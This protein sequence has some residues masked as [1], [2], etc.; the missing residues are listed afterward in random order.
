MHVFQRSM[1]ANNLA[2]I[3]AVFVLA[4]LGGSVITGLL[5]VSAFW[6]LVY[7]L[8]GRIRPKFSAGIAIFSIVLLAYVAVNIL[9]FIVNFGEVF[10]EPLVELR[11]IAPQ[12][13]FLAAIPIMWRLAISPGESLLPALWRGAAIGA[14]AVLPLALFQLYGLGDRAEGG[15]GN[16]IPFALTSALLSVTSLAG[17]LDDNRRFRILAGAGFVSGYICVF[18]A[19]TKGL[20]PVPLVCALVFA[21]VFFRQRIRIGQAVGL[22]VLLATLVI[23]GLYGSGSHKRFHDV[24]QRAMGDEHVE[25]DASY[26]VRWDIWVKAVSAIADAPL[27]GHG[28]Q[29]RRAVIQSFGYAYSHMHNG[30]LTAM[31]D[32]GVLGLVTL[33]GLL[34]SPLYIAWRA[35]R[36]TLYGRRLFL[37]FSLVA[38]YAIGG[39]T[40]F[41]FGHDIYDALFLWTGIVIAV[42]ATPDPITDE[43][44]A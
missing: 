21:I 12:I 33:L 24:A 1:T 43:L 13:L 3:Y 17:L 11:K 35:P 44:S 32:N 39:L 9:F 26:S 14:I 8:I 18:L 38:T 30:Y 41:I 2:A 28:V 31:V 29:N 19:Q 5:I 37:A 36:N 34:L 22:L 20:M 15:S 23:A 16:A 42:S 10:T 7:V 27:E 40:N 25:L 6:A 4:A